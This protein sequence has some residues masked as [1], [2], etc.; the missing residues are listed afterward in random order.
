MY[1]DCKKSILTMSQAKLF[2]ITYDENAYKH[3]KSIPNR[4]LYNKITKIN[5]S[6]EPMKSGFK[7]SVETF[8]NAS[9]KLSKSHSDFFYSTEDTYRM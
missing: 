7:F 6:P 9:L 5:N 2:N 1:V 8:D 3:L 4:V